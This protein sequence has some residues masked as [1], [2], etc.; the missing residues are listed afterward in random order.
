LFSFTQEQEKK[1]KTA[2]ATILWQN[3]VSEHYFHIQTM[4]EN[5]TA[6]Y[7]VTTIAALAG[8]SER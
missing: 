4:K 3:K 8:H 5:S 1:A 2:C 7:T 6:N